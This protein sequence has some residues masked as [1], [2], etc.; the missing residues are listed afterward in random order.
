MSHWRSSSRLEGRKV[1]GILFESNN[2]WITSSWPIQHNNRKQSQCHPITA[3]FPAQNHSN[4]KLSWPRILW[5]IVM[6]QLDTLMAKPLIWIILAA[7]E[8]THF[9]FLKSWSSSKSSQPFASAV[10]PKH[11][12]LGH[13][14]TI[15]DILASE[16]NGKTWAIW[17]FL[18]HGRSPIH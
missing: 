6:L 7:G 14:A 15:S 17:G 18:C 10:V 9:L 8:T 1:S 13:D 3:S 2:H 4:M 12:D 16:S 5:I 11:L